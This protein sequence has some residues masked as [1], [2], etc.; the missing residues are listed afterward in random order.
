[1]TLPSA[2][3]QLGDR[4]DPAEVGGIRGQRLLQYHEGIE[5]DFLLFTLHEQFGSRQQAIHLAVTGH[6]IH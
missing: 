3:Q 1:M 2:A 5:G 6:Q 4:F